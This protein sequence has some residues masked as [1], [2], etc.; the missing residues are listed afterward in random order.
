VDPLAD[1]PR[2]GGISTYAFTNN[3][4]VNK[5]DPNGLRP[6]PLY[7]KFK[8]WTWRVDSWFGSRNTGLPGASKFHRGLDFNYSGG[9]ETD[10]GSSILTTHDGVVTTAD[11]NNSGGE[12]RMVVVTASNRKF[13][14]RYF[15]LSQIN[16]GKGE[17]VSESTVIGEM[18]GSANGKEKGRQVHL[19]YEIQKLNADGE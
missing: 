9:G 8:S 6:I 3:D 7:D 5:I 13:R 19:H 16:V 17:E 14:T 2:Q 10:Y 4:P 11:D 15:H 12:G 18:G 1:H